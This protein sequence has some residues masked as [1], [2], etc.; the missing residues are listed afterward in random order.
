MRIIGN[1]TKT[2]PITSILTLTIVASMLIAF[3]PFTFAQIG[4]PVIAMTASVGI[5]LDRY[6]PPIGVNDPILI[7]GFLYPRPIV[8]GDVYEDLEF[9]FTKPDGTKETIV[10]DSNTRAEVWFD[11]ACDQAGEWELELYWP[12]DEFH[13]DAD[14]TVEW[15]VVSTPQPSILKKI[16]TYAYASTSPKDT[17]GQGQSIYIVGWVTPP[18]CQSGPIY[19]DYSF[20]ITKPNGTTDTIVKDS[21]SEAST[22]FGYLCD[23]VGTWSVTL[24]YPGDQIHTGAVS[25]PWT[26]T[27]QEEPVPIDPTQPIPDYQWEYPVSAEYYEW[28]QITGAWPGNEYN[29][30]RENFNPYTKGPNT[31]HIIWKKDNA[32]AGMVGQLGYSARTTGGSVPISVYGKL[33]TRDTIGSGDTRYPVLIATDIFTG[34]ELWRSPLP[35]DPENPGASGGT[36]YVEFQARVKVDPKL[37]PRPGGVVSIWCIG[38]G[39]VWELDPFDGGTRYFNPDLPSGTYHDGAIYFTD[40]NA[41]S[42]K[43]EDNVMTKWDTRFQEVLWVANVSGGWDFMWEDIIFEGYQGRGQ[44]PF[45][46]KII[47][48]NATTGN[49]IVEGPALEPYSTESAGRT[50]VAYGQWYFHSSTTLSVHAVDLLTGEM[51]WTSEPNE[52]PWGVFGSYDAAAGYGNYYQGTW[53]GYVSCYDAETGATK[54]R[55]FLGD[56]P[57]IATGHNIP[58]G[59]PIIADNK[60]FICSSEHTYPT[61]IPGG[62]KLYALD[63]HTGD[64]LWEMPMYNFQGGIASGVLFGTN[65]YDGCLYGFAKG[66]SA[67]TVTVQQ[68]VIAKGSSALIKGTVTDQSAGAKDTPAIADEDMGEWMQYLYMNKPMPTDATGVPVALV[69]IASDGNVIDIGQATS[70]SGGQFSLLWTP[71]AQGTYRI[72]ASFDG[73]GSYYS[74]W[75][76]TSLGVTAAPS[77]S[78]PIEPEP[79]ASLGITEIAIIAA[80]VVAVIVGI[81]AFWALRKRK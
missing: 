29:E 48:W 28:Y 72:I 44:N 40:Y 11:Y 18:P 70:T 19:Y 67:T 13:E 50:C 7:H 39:G 49:L 5:P 12:G 65:T 3:A 4:K 51:A 60:V 22:S 8:A 6:I 74:S 35:T 71:P 2:I 15:T 77:P 54:W 55:T 24:S 58:W 78:G 45:G 26:W 33:Y 32:G 75:G 20:T 37:G 52:A 1:K 59:Q 16:Q 57:N 63:A 14:D 38:G 73:S 69:A 27:V 36:L 10:K 81:V 21:N 79:T 17:I 56:N 46:Q 66:P 64:K 43:S 9:T 80:V 23:Q 61:P 53:D 47:T 62:N 76:E 42:G 30:A 68:D 41:T 31:P 25:E 34:E